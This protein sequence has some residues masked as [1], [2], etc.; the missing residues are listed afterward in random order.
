MRPN[1]T[2]G[3]SV[4]L[5]PDGGSGGSDGA[6]HRRR[7]TNHVRLLPLGR[8]R[9]ILGYKEGGEKWRRGVKGGEG[10]VKGGEGG[11]KGGE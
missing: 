3:A 10:D 5:G 1:L 4:D 6:D 2:F 7:G 9:R 8:D 11:M